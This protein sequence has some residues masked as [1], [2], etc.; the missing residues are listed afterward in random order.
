MGFHFSAL[1]SLYALSV[2]RVH[3]HLPIHRNMSGTTRFLNAA[4]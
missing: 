1:P 2:V 3:L 4:N